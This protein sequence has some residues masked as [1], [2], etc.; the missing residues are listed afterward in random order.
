MS[1][2]QTPLF[3]NRDLRKLLI[4]LMLEQFLSGFIG[5]ADTMMVTRVGDTAIS[6]VSCVDSVNTLMLY[7]FA[8]LA[9]GGTIVCSQYLGRED[10]E[11]A[12]NAAK[13]L[14]L[15]AFVLSIALM[16]V[17]ILLR[18]PIL[19]LVFGSVEQEIMEQALGY[20]LITAL[21][22]PFLALQQVTAAQ[23]RAEGNSRL[24][25]L[26]TAAANLV[27]IIGNA[28]L[29]FGMGLGVA[30][31]AIATLVSRI[32]ACVVL[33]VMQKRSDTRI[34]VGRYLDIRPDFSVIRLVLRIGIPSAVENGL[35]Q[36][37]R[38]VVQSTVSTLG[39]TAIAAQAMTYMMDSFQS[40][41]GQAVGLGMLTVVGTCLGAGRV[42]E[43]KRNVKKLCIVCEVLLLV[44]CPLILAICKPAM[45]LSGMTGEAAAL[46]FRLLVYISIAK[47]ILWDLAFCLPNA[48]RASGDAAYSAAVSGAS[49][50]IC[51]VGLSWL[52]CRHLGVGLVGVWIAWFTDWIVRL[53]FYVHRW[54]SGKWMEKTVLER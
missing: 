42:D 4:P 30:G 48:L 38:L 18:A 15:S 9:T 26:V 46:T 35:F 22:Y 14:Y 21:S 6:A 36:F 47:V 37:G 5:I 11:G 43:A 27:N 45:A 10:R 16:A 8:A 52:L 53:S 39:T 13:Q 29:I 51:R 31:A 54:F 34:R 32:L 40:M 3:S 49:M 25:M 17:C 23:L 20:F 7:L 1:E 2:Q 19:K 24:P 28:W 41:P 33:M 50:W 44:M 12:N